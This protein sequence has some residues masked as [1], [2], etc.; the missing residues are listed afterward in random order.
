MNT[1]I[2]CLLFLGAG[3]AIGREWYRYEMGKAWDD[4]QL[5]VRV[6]NL[7]EGSK[8]AWHSISFQV[9]SNGLPDESEE[10]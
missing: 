8:D 4:G 6:G 1:V 5:M 7:W 3:I 9:L 10:E 2:L